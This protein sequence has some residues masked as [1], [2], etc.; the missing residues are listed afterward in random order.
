MMA[1]CGSGTQGCHGWIEQYREESRE[2]GWLV[3]QG[4]KP[5]EV[6][7]AYRGR[8]SWL[9]EGG[10]VIAATAFETLTLGKPRRL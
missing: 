1:L 9:T 7:V 10:L 6:P 3:P 2:Q 8:W 5:E 4:V